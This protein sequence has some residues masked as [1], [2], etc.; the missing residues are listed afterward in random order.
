MK[1][2]FSGVGNMSS[3]IIRGLINARVPAELH[4]YSPSGPKKSL[5]FYSQ[6]YWQPNNTTLADVV[7]I[8]VLG[9]KPQ[10]IPQVLQDMRHVK[11][12]F[13]L[14]I[15]LAAGVTTQ[16]LLKNIPKEKE[17][18]VIRAMP[19][20]PSEVIHMWLIA[21]CS[22]APFQRMTSGTQSDDPKNT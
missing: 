1:I 20:T 18:G 9:V 10:V 22:E 8:L 19:N 2:G 14:V 16:T 17:S 3:A 11:D 6:L 13:P 5:D 21:F 12:D 4:A 15:S 7:D